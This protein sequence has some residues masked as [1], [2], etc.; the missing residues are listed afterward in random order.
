[1]LLQK[2]YILE[3]FPCDVAIQGWKAM[4]IWYGFDA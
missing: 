2:N 1:M 3:N 4:S